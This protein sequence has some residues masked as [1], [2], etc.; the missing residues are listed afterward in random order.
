MTLAKHGA[1]HIRDLRLVGGER[2]IEE[3]RDHASFTRG[4]LART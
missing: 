4:D 2:S 3:D 1:M